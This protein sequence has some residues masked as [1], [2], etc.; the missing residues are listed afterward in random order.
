[1][2]GII[3]FPVLSAINARKG[4]FLVA[5]TKLSPYTPNCH[6]ELILNCHAEFVSVSLLQPTENQQQRLIQPCIL[7]NADT[8]HKESPDFRGFLHFHPHPACASPLSPQGRGEKGV[9][10]GAGIQERG[11]RRWGGNGRR[12]ELR[13]AWTFKGEGKK[14]ACGEKAEIE[15]AVMLLNRQLSLF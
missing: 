4:V 12:K 3:Y 8:T 7:I 14:A 15:L 10:A 5:P 9:V 11:K 2:N 1:M 13:L 6:A